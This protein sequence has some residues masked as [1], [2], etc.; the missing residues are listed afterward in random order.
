MNIDRLRYFAAVVETKNLRKAADLVGIAPASMSKAI[1]TLSDELGI[2]LIRA[3][4]RGIEIT[5]KGLDVFRA[6]SVLLD[7]YFRFVDRTQSVLLERK[8]T[9]LRFASFE[10][11]TGSLLS[12][13]FEEFFPTE[14]IL[15]LEKVPGEIE[16]AISAGIVDYGLTYVPMPKDNLDFTE[17]GNFQMKIYGKKSWA[18][19]PFSEWPFAVPTTE[20]RIHSQSTNSLDLWT[21]IKH[22]RL[23]RFKFELLETALQTSS[24]GISGIFLDC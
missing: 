2:E 13:F 12:T 16:E 6:S 18:S 19:V 1:S 3:E 22:P 14:E 17:V 20:V 7:E 10:V 24:K 5:E 21:D 4:G 15:L 23:V 9:K 8:G 11:F